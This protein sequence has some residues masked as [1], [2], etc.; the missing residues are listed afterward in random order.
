M[1]SYK[2]LQKEVVI[3]A[4]EN[5]QGI[6]TT[7]GR[8]LGCKGDTAERLCHR[9]KETE[10]AL[11]N[12]VNSVLDLAESKIFK[13]INDGDLPTIKWYLT[14]KGQGRGY[15][16]TPTIKL[17]NGEPLNITFSNMSKQDFIDSSNV[18]VSTG[19]EGETEES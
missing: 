2:H 10:Q 14:M 3:A 13:A 1:A 8:R 5:S 19:A 6:M 7:I 4:I 16:S 9:W 15:I 18:E 17:D 12:E 11:I